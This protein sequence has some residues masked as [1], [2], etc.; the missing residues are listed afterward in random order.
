VTDPIMMAIAAALAGKA[1][2]AVID[3]GRGA[4]SSLVRLIRTRFAADPEATGI[5]DTA[6]ADPDDQDNVRELAE[7]VDR[8]AIRDAEFAQRLRNL[9][10][11]AQADLRVGSDVFN[12]NSGSVRGHLVQGRDIGGG[13]HLGDVRSGEQP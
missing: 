11:Q 9:W 3:G 12:S 2:E 1:G 6:Q 8:I 10:P 5:L 13:L 4:W 7:T